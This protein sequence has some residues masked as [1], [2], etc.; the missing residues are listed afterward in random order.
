MA[1]DVRRLQ[2]D[3]ASS[4]LLL[5]TNHLHSKNYRK[6]LLQRYVVR[7]LLMYR[8]PALRLLS[9]VLNCD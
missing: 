6:P 4:D 7:I 3:S 1:T 9:S 8:A 2:R 5:I